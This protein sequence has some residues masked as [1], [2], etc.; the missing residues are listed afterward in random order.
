MKAL[1]KYQKGKGNM[2]LRDIPEP[3]PSDDQIKIEVKA[4]G[5][6]G[7]DIHI[8]ND[9][10]SM[11][12]KL[13]VVPGHELVG[14]IVDT[15]KKVTNWNAG[16]RII[17]EDTYSSCGNCMYCLKGLYNLCSQRK[18]LG[19]WYNGGFEKYTVVPEERIHKL[20]DNL[21]FV[22]ATLIQPLSCAV[23]A[24]EELIK[25][26]NNDVILITG[27]GVIGLSCLQV[28]KTYN[29]TV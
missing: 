19:Y 18:C 24:I 25:I 17:A 7:S 4:A 6:C 12:M 9:T 13:P 27:P 26:K 23:H 16:D 22:E 20:P 2:E 21:D 15:G 11:P 1:V 10:I 5:I 8:Y 14:V 28:L 3:F 29:A